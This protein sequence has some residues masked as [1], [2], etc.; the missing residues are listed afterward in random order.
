MLA[1]AGAALLIRRV[2]PLREG[3]NQ[4]FRLAALIGLVLFALHGI[5][6]VSAHRVGTAYSAVF[7]LGLAFYRPLPLTSSRAIAAIFRIMGAL[8]C[9][10]GLACAI[11]AGT[12][13]LLPGSVGVTN[14]KELAAA[15]NRERDFS[16][17]VSLTSR[18]RAWAPLDWQLYFL[19]A[20][21]EVADKQGEVAL[22]DFQRARFLE[23]NGF[24]V[25][26]AE[27]NAWLPT[28]PT[29]AVSAWREALRRAG[30]RRAEIF[31][32]VLANAA[33]ENPAAS[34]MLEEIGLARH[35]LV[36]PYLNRVSGED[37]QRAIKQV[38]ANDPELKTFTEPEKIAFFT[39]WSERGV[40]DSLAQEVQRHPSWM[41]YAW[42]GLA[43]YYAARKDFRAAYELTQ[44]YGESVA[45]PRVTT[46][47]SLDD[48]QNRFA[49]A[50]DNYA[51]GYALY[52]AQIQRGRVD[53]ALNTARH[54]SERASAPAYFHLLEAE[55]WAAKQNWER[56]WMAW[57]AFEA[58]KAK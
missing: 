56:A 2:F 36:M 32:I 52:R 12:K 4:R 15:A 45:L 50:P 7:L 58:A 37:F 51:L 24:E 31:S 19:R 1:L 39:L 22:E 41:P 49:S 8:L 10:F 6:D 23:P 48:L 9:V 43:K 16:A 13:T 25:P 40:L 55:C 21:A 54:F 34:R 44:R 11:A 5:V 27:G 17:A 29:L 18:A 20:L 30:P 53:D 26:L 35:D 3:T 42:L 47:T 28:Q 14:A 33:N 57:Q 38:L 46:D